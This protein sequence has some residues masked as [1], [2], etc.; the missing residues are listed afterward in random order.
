MIYAADDGQKFEKNAGNQWS[1]TKNQ[2]LI[3]LGKYIYSERRNLH[4]SENIYFPRLICNVFLV[5]FH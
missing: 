4:L 2:F 3:S 1:V 5:T